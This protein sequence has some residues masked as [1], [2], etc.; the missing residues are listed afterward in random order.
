M[1][2]V[3]AEPINLPRKR[4]TSLSMGGVKRPRRYRPGTVALR[5]IRKY[6]T[7]TDT[8][9]PKLC[10]QRLVKEIMCHVCRERHITM[11]KIQSTALLA[12]QTAAEYYLTELFSKSQLLAIHG[13]RVTVKPED[14]QI[15]RCLGGEGDVKDMF[16][17]KPN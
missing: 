2:G 10:F 4:S 7:S 17:I 6:Q 9:I 8:L 15:V 13:N 12:L 5:E 11:M 14:V 1:M 3:P 16:S